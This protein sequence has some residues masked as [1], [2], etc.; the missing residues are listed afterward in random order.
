MILEGNSG[1]LEKDVTI[2]KK[3]LDFY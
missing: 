2:Y 3:G 1:Y